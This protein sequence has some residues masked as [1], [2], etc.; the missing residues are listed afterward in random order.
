M[1]LRSVGGDFD[2][3]AAARPACLIF[4]EQRGH[5]DVTL[6]PKKYILRGDTGF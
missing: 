1:G 2:D 5:D 6:V 3:C 4:L